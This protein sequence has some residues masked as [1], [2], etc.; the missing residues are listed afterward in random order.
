MALGTDLLTLSEPPGTGPVGGDFQFFGKDPNLPNQEFR[1]PALRL[2]VPADVDPTGGA[3][4]VAG[5]GIVFTTLPSGAIEIST[6]VAIPT[7]VQAPAAPA[8]GLVD[9]TANTLSGLLVPGFPA[10]AD[11]EA[12]GVPGQMGIVNLAAIAGDDVQGGRI[13]SR[14]LTGAIDTSATGIRVAASGNRPAGAW[15]LNDRA[16]TGPAVNAKGYQPTYTDT[17]PSA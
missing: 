5:T 4:Y 12:F 15:L 17:Y 1:V 6:N 10:V 9:D 13:Y 7:P 11:Y 3:T 14:G 2:P 8:Y 16:F